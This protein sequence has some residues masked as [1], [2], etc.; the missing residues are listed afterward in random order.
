MSLVATD[1][2]DPPADH[3]EA[4]GERMDF[5]A[6]VLG[7]GDREKT[8][9]L[10]AEREHHVGGVLDDDDVVLTGEVDHLAEELFWSPRHPW[11]CWGS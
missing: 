1:P 10:G 11:G 3:V 8:Q 4:F 7:A 5:D 9:R 2:T 6:D